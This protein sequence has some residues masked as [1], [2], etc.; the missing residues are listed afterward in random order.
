M[1]KYFLRIW[2]REKAC[3]D[4]SQTL[5]SFKHIS[6]SSLAE[7]Y[8]KFR[9][10]H[11]INADYLVGVSFIRT[12]S[13]TTGLPP[14]RLRF[15]TQWFNKDII[16]RTRATVFVRVVKLSLRI[17]RRREGLPEYGNCLS[18][19]V[20]FIIIVCLVNGGSVRLRREERKVGGVSRL[21]KILFKKEKMR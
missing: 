18:T 2:P 20:R 1:F 6:L 9:A 13:T 12:S 10:R 15:W 14:T 3:C 11:V 4:S 17:A 7:P 16:A 19:S 5:G 8:W 21:A